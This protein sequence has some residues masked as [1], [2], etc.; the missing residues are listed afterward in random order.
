VLLA[1][2]VGVVVEVVYDQARPV[3]RKYDVQFEQK[4][5]DGARDSA[6]AR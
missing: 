2:A 5:A 6:L 1:G 3:L 4:A